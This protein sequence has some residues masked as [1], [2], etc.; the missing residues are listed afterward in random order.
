MADSHKV[1]VRVASQKGSCEAGHKVND[2]WIIDTK[3][4]EGICLFA[5]NSLFP[6]LQVLAFGGSFPWEADPDV[7]TVACPDP[8][9]PV[10]F[11]LRRLRE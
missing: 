4:P 6:S 8:G 5:F 2:Q 7:T 9:N 1:S 11:K 10:V 3:T